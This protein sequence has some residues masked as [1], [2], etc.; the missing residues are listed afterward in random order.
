MVNSPTFL[1]PPES[2]LHPS[3]I[4]TYSTVLIGDKK[5]V[6]HY[7]YC[8][9]K[10]CCLLFFV[11]QT[12]SMPQKSC[13]QYSISKNLCKKKKKKRGKQHNLATEE[14]QPHT[15]CRCKN[16]TVTITGP[17]E[18][19]SPSLPRWPAAAGLQERVLALLQHCVRAGPLFLRWI[20]GP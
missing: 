17:A 19:S 10:W 4:S 15:L 6:L 18:P 14:R 3:C 20:P 5:Q 7:I 16:P 9:I 1:P 13:W 12:S 8:N 11:F 2:P